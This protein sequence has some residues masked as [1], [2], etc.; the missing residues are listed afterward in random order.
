M[1]TITR[2]VRIHSC[3]QPAI[4]SNRLG[5]ETQFQLSKEISPAAR[6]EILS[7]IGQTIPDHR[8]W[9]TVTNPPAEDRRIALIREQNCSDTTILSGGHTTI[10]RID[11]LKLCLSLGFELNAMYIPTRTLGPALSVSIACNIE[12]F[13]FHPRFLDDGN[14]IDGCSVTFLYADGSQ[15][16]SIELTIISVICRTCGFSQM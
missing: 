11:L 2:A 7:A 4:S 10:R 6:A 16:R 8:F 5:I 12:P 15:N 1:C 14:R 9:I 13:N 3:V